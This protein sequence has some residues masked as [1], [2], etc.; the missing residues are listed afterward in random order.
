MATSEVFVVFVLGGA[1]TRSE[2]NKHLLSQNSHVLLWFSSTPGGQ[3]FQHC[4]LQSAS[5]DRTQCAA[6]GNAIEF[7]VDARNLT[8]LI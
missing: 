5:L 8:L 1:V 3:N 7:N 2:I 4:F 6:T